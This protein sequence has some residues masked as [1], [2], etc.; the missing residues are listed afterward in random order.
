[1]CGYSKAPQVGSGLVQN[2]LRHVGSPMTGRSSVQQ[3]P[4][5]GCARGVAT[6]GAQVGGGPARDV[7][8]K[9]RP[10]AAAP[11]LPRG[12]AAAARCVAA[13]LQGRPG[14]P[15]ARPRPRA[16]HRAAHPAPTPAPKST[17]LTRLAS[18]DVE[19]MSMC[20]AGPHYPCCRRACTAHQAPLAGQP[21]PAE[22]ERQTKVSQHLSNEAQLVAK[23]PLRRKCPC[24]ASNTPKQNQGYEQ[25]QAVTLL[26]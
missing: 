20:G 24:P 9:A 5:A 15:C 25:G 13:S 18:S 2:R 4:A 22:A 8:R 10:A 17:G 19:D 1:M 3:R 14:G 6:D 26:Q 7:R 16:P 11:A 23:A 12:C 21:V